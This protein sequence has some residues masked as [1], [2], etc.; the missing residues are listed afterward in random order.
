LISLAI[1][2]MAALCWGP[3]AAA[4]PL[5]LDDD[6]DKKADGKA[7]DAGFGQYN[8]APP[9]IKLRTYTLAE[10]LALADRNHPNLWAAR[11]RLA[12]TH[13]QLDEVTWLP[14]WQMSANMKAGVLP[15]ITGTIGYTS[16]P[17]SAL[18]L[19]WGD[20]LFPAYSFDI[21]GALP[22]YTFGKITAGKDAAAAQVRV[23]EWDLERW[24]Q[25]A[26][27]DVRRAYFGLLLARDA[28]YIIDDVI[29]RLN[30]AIDGI[31]SKLDKGDT[32]VDE[33]DRLR[34]LVYRDEIQARAGEATRGETFALAAL[35]YLTGVQTGFDVPDEPLKRPDV[36]LAPV[37]RYLAA[38]RVLRPEISM[39]RAG[40]AAREAQVRLQRARYWPDIGIFYAGTYAVAP[41]AVTQDVALI[42]NPFNHFYVYGGFGMNWA[43]DLLPNSARVAR[44]EADLE[45]TRA[46][47][48]RALG[49]VAVEVE[50]Q[51][52]VV[53][54][55]MNREAA[56]DRAEHRSKQW[57]S[58]VQ[59][60]IDLGTK[61]ENAMN[62]PIRAYVNARVNHIYS[63]MDLNVGMSELARVSGWDNSAPKAE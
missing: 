47:L 42:P 53:V 30:K 50:N 25:V 61:N 6:D 31:A 46:L 29:S 18:N 58:T 10:C 7:P 56:W 36:P 26:R 21:N 52:A 4:G 24:R 43:L 3:H 9:T 32:S 54:E 34:L 27:M 22:L 11:A 2:A 40:V 20:K 23:F 59:D 57:I 33:I 48:R 41:G 8:P 62:E 39:A 55:A 37:I 1:V 45:E 15:P 35:R 38:A 63:L 44:T 5:D 49:E 16:T 14:F 19:G 51:H 28:R 13:A 12:S 60:Q 17:V